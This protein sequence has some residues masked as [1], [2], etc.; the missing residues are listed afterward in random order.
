MLHEGDSRGKGYCDIEM[1]HV[2]TQ[3]GQVKVA[4]ATAIAFASFN[5][6]NIVLSV[7]LICK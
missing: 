3:V 6:C 5:R 4:Q 7:G 1:Y 2:C